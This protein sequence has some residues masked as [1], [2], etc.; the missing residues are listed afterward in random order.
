M[1]LSNRKRASTAR[2]S[3]PRI[4][5]AFIRYGATTWEYQSET[6]KHL[7]PALPPVAAHSP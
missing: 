7:N 4:P 6:A 2:L 5:E 3:L 1:L